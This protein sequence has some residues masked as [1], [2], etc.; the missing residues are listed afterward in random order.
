MCVGGIHKL[1][2]RENVIFKE[3]HETLARFLKSNDMFL[4]FLGDLMYFWLRDP[5]SGNLMIHLP[6]S[7]KTLVRFVIE[8]GWKLSKYPPIG[9]G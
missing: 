8:K 5:T 3:G 9:A 7:K 4:L 2:N 1:I 6:M